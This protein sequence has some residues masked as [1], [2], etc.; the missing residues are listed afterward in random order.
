[1]YLACRVTLAPILTG[2]SFNM[3]SDR[4][5]TLFES[6]RWRRKFPRL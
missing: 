3:V 2:Y 4:C 5:R 6:A 1:M